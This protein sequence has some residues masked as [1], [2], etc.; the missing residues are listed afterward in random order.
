MYDS[1]MK[2][3]TVPLAMP[4]DL[5]REMRQVAK[6]TGLS[7]ADVMRQSMKLGAP[8][9]REELSIHKLKPM[10]KEECR[11]A[12]ETPNPEFD[13]LETHCAKLLKRPP[14]EE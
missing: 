4:P 2:S 7:I 13:A 6:E 9:L 10:T 14:E 11:L 8:K 12:F 3:E 1:S 5:L